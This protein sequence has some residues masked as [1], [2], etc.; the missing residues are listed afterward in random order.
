MIFDEN[1]I[2]FLMISESIST[3]TY[4]LLQHELWM[5]CLPCAVHFQNL[6]FNNDQIITDE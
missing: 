4:S 5:K 1:Y 2:L 6:K 3:D